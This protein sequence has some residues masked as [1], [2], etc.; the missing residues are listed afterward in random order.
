MYEEYFYVTLPYVKTFQRKN[1]YIYRKKKGEG[2][3]TK[4]AKGWDDFL[5]GSCPLAKQGFIHFS[6]KCQ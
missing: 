6:S 4:R 2:Q 5:N 1:I 3:V